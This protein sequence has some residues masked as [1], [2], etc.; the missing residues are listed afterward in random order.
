MKIKVSVVLCS[1]RSEDTKISEF[2][3]YKKSS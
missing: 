1:V 3:L 2:N